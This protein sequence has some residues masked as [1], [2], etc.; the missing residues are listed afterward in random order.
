MASGN[1]LGSFLVYPPSLPLT[2]KGFSKK[3][4]KDEMLGVKLYSGIDIHLPKG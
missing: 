1:L 2:T 4:A 3:K